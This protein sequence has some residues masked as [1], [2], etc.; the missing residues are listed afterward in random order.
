MICKCQIILIEITMKHCIIMWYKDVN[1]NQPLCVCV[2][3]NNQIIVIRSDIGTEYGM[4]IL[5]TLNQ[6][7]I[8]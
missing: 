5:I 7:F 8:L 1:I 2:T 3:E 4:F 6:Q